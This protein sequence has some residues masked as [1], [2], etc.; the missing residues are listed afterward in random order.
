M[1]QRL[2]KTI[3]WLYRNGRPLDVARYEYLFL[4]KNK[5]LVEKILRSYQNPDGGFGHGLEPDSQNPFSSPIQGWTAL[6]II[7]ELELDGNHLIV[8][9]LLDYFI[10]KA[11]KK[12]DFYLAT[13]P[14]NNSYPHASWWTYS[15][16]GSIW[17][18]NPTIAIAGFIYVYSLENDDVENS[19]KVIQ[20]A[21]D[22]FCKNPSNN[23][24]E[25][26]A[27][28]EMVNRIKDLSKFNNHQ[29]FLEKLLEQ[30]DFNIESNSDL[31]FKTYCVRPL[32]FFDKPNLFGYQKFETLAIKEAQMILSFLNKEGYWDITWDWDDYPE[33]KLVAKRDWQSI[34][35]IEYLKILRD[36][37]II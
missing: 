3:A 15:S 37:K 7:E 14:S 25:L 21:I 1:D 2:D 6:E 9:D 13:I 28:L 5:D 34:M 19:K 24:H 33:F 11:P 17:G 23:M 4:N 36:Y 26:R 32:Q 31:W 18:Y 22:D 16:E 30:I 35:I 20:K 8:K 29:L 10:N 27:F 12:D